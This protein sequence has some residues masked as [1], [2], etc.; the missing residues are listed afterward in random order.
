[1]DPQLKV[2]VELQ[3]KIRGQ[4]RKQLINEFAIKREEVEAQAARGE[5]LEAVARYRIEELDSILQSLTADK[6]P[7]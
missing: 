5:L 3:H 7:N 2:R 6:L 4:L 1:V